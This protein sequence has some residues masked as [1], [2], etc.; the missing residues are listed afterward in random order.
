L[1]KEACLKVFECG[2]SPENE[3]VKL[4]R[5]A[6]IGLNNKQ[7]INMSENVETKEP[8][9]IQDDGEIGIRP[10][11]KEAQDGLVAAWNAY[12]RLPLLSKEEIGD[13]RQAIDQC[14]GLIARR[15]ARRVNPGVWN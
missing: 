15:V 14:H 2:I 10:G 1:L 11:E 6:L 12:V 9:A 3:N 13:F 8:E 5:T 4:L 7:V